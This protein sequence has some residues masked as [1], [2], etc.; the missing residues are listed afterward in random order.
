[1]TNQ[2]GALPLRRVVGLPGS[3]GMHAPVGAGSHVPCHT[4]EKPVRDRQE[5]LHRERDADLIPTLLGQALDC[6]WRSFKWFQLQLPSECPWMTAVKW[7]SF[8]W[9]PATL[10]TMQEEQNYCYFKPLGFGTFFF[11]AFIAKQ[12]RNESNIVKY[13]KFSLLVI[14]HSVSSALEF[15]H[16]K[17]PLPLLQPIKLTLSTLIGREGLY[18]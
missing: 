17:D 11:F 16:K 2:F 4:A 5:G 15:E 1:M 13:L 12:N 3:L 18:D 10:I 9:H 7:E 8:H 6:E 14:S